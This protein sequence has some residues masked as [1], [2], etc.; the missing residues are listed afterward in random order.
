LKNN[1]KNIRLILILPLV[2]LIGVTTIAYLSTLTNTETNYFQIG[3]NPVTIEE[4]FDGWDTKEVR[5]AMGTD[6]TDVPSVVRAM[7]VPYI[8]DADGNYI[9]CDLAGFS[10]P[11]DNRMALGDVT[12]VFDDSWEDYWVYDEDD[13]YFYYR[14]VL[15]PEDGRNQTEPLLS[16]VIPTDRDGFTGSYGDDAY[17][18]VEVL[19][20]ILQAE[21]GSGEK[22]GIT[23]DMGTDPGTVTKP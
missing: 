18:K 10:A 14:Y 11:V 22:W 21:G 19:A 23:I 15:Y 17:V 8:V 5:L 3:K 13:C 20:D 4:D 9:A 7:V 6:A 2:A 1:R 12:L 16:R